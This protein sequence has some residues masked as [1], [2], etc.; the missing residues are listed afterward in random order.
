MQ[1]A[2]VRPV[3][4]ARHT[5]I[6][7]ALFLLLTLAGARFQS[8]ARS[9]A[10]PAPRAT[11][12]VPLY[13]SL[14]AAE[15]GLA[16]YVWR[17]LKRARTEA[18]EVIGGPWSSAPAVLDDLAS[19]AGLWGVWKL[20]GL[21]WNRVFGEGHAASIAGYL[22]QSALEV[23]LWVGLSITA[24]FVEEF[25]FR[26]YLL[27]QLEA[28]TRRSWLAILLQAAVFGLSHGYQGAQ[29]RAKITVFGLLF[30]IVARWR[31]SLRPGMIAHAATDVIAGLRI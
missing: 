27:R 11:P 20:I 30:A 16:F 18:R 23:V 15:W 31:R 17:G 21:G 5:A 28:W 7:I 22:P 13:L 9:G 1:S 2:R 3:A 6:L 14:M 24:G 4:S 29:A 25:V 8:A 19:A 26:G 10:V 12:V